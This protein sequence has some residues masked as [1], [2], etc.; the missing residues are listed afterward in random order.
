MTANVR[1]LRLL[2]AVPD[3][4]P[5]ILV[6]PSLGVVSSEDLEVGTRRLGTRVVS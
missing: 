1:L 4:S 5:A 3:D 2:K 6:L